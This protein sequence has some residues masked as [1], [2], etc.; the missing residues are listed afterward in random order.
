MWRCQISSH[1]PFHPTGVD[2]GP[3]C[4]LR[5]KACV[6]VLHVAS[7][8]TCETRRAGT[9]VLCQP[10]PAW[11]VPHPEDSRPAG[12][13][14]ARPME[15]QEGLWRL[16]AGPV[17]QKEPFAWSSSVRGTLQAMRRALHAL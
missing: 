8:L 4:A 13:A 11:L 1:A 17:V 15:T 10:G 12:A 5:V 14:G 9:R 6:S 16:L 7:L 2:A 3:V